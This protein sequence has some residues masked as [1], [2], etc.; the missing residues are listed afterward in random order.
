MERVRVQDE[1]PSEYHHYARWVSQWNMEAGEI[2][3][4]TTRDRATASGLLPA[5]GDDDW[6]FLDDERL[7]VMEFDADGTMTARRLV[8]DDASLARARTLWRL[9]LAAVPS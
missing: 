7:I 8:T 9:A 6:W 1:P 4:Y 3:H 5:A 2:I